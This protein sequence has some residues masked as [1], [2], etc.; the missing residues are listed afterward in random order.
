MRTRRRRLRGRP[1]GLRRLRWPLRARAAARRARRA[2][3]RACTPQPQPPQPPVPAIPAARAGLAA[4]AL[5]YAVSLSYLTVR[6]HHGFGTAGFDIG[7][8][9]QGIWLLSRF[10]TPLVTVRGLHL[11][12]DHASFALLGVVPL[13]WL[14]PS[15]AVL[16][17]AQSVVLAAGAVPTFLIARDRLRSEWLALGCALAYLA[18]PALAWINFENFHPDSLEVPLVLGAFWLVL[19]RR[20][21]WFL[22]C[23]A[24]L[25]LVKED[26]ALLT[27]GL[28]VYVTLRHHRTVGLATAGMSGAWLLLTVLVIVP[29]FNP[30]GYL[31]AGRLTDQ[32]GGTGALASSVLTSPWEVAALAL[33]P[34]Q[35]WYLWQ[36]LTSFALLPL[37]A[38]VVLAVAAG[39][40]VSNLLSTFPYQYQIEYHYS[41]LILPVLAVA[42]IVGFARFRSMRTRKVLV[43]G[44]AAGA[45]AGAYLWGPLGRDP[46][47]VADPGAPRAQA[48]REAIA[49]I[50]PDAAVSASYAY[51]PHLTHREQ[52]YE[53]PNPWRATNWGDWSQEGT[54]LPS[55]SD[56]DYLL[57]STSTAEDPDHGPLLR[58]LEQAGFERRYQSESVMVLVRQR[59]GEGSG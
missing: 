1:P 11:F 3:L 9:D 49:L 52:I 26:A 21:R 4:A 17:V 15:A 57:I 47:S 33:G 53:F 36:L 13:Y 37:L 6:N 32:F 55:A 23:V 10:E 24:V 56:V 48:A 35:R 45:L 27:F 8:F 29:A 34:E 5:A 41:T 44:M 25:L 28:G 54:R 16:L 20:W 39:P 30:A 58:W 46:A 50:P 42:A 59:A 2:V 51:V 31:Y 19:T 38:P 22:A 7:I 18:H 40:L 14:L 12:G 43:A